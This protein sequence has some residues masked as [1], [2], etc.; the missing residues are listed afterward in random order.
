[1]NDKNPVIEFLMP[2]HVWMHSKKGTPSVVIALTNTHLPEKFLENYPVQVVYVDAGGNITSASVDQFIKYREFHHVE[3]RIEAGV[4]SMVE[5]FYGTDGDEEGED[6]DS[7]EL[8]DDDTSVTDEDTPVA[9][10]VQS[11]V[12]ARKERY[13]SC[14]IEFASS[15]NE[16]I[17][18]ISA[19]LLELN[20]V[21][22]QNAP[23]QDGG[24]LHCLR[25]SLNDE[26][27]NEDLAV[28]FGSQ[29]VRYSAFEIQG[30]PV[31]WDQFIGV[32][33][34]V[35]AGEVYGV[36][37][38]TEFG[39]VPATKAPAKAV[40]KTPAK[41]PAKPAA[42]TAAKKPVVKADPAVAEVVMTPPVG[43]GENSITSGPT[44]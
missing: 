16:A 22:Y 37:M 9:S 30:I 14:S 5:S 42:K 3:P 12:Y 25:F 1:M 38:F 43:E 28:A 26:L 21:E 44:E 2:G 32:Y 8:S 34:H 33:P 29:L 10:D 20:V 19:E 36:A 4:Q 17:P 24:L 6:G 27:T 11:R 13:A 15:T 23:T 18:V 40:A 7:I 39:D 41:T 31:S 35:I